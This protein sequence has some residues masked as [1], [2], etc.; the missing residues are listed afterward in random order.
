MDR[1]RP[2]SSAQFSPL[3]FAAS[4]DGPIR[5]LEASMRRRPVTEGIV[6]I[7]SATRHADDDV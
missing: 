4:K 1:V 3:R 7:P 2:E 5:H 6:F